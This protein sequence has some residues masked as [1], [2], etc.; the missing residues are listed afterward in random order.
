MKRKKEISIIRSSAYHL[1]ASV[2]I[3]MG[4]YSE[5]EEVLDNI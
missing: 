3:G 2:L 4:A 1:L 5:A